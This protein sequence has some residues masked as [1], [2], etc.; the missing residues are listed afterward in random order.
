MLGTGTDPNTMRPPHLRFELEEAE[1]R[2]ASEEAGHYVGKDM[3]MVY[4]TPHGS[5]D[6]IPREP[7]PW[8]E[9]C[10]VDVR[11]G[12]LNP[13]W[14]EYYRLAYKNWKEGLEPPVV[15]TDIKLAGFL[16]PR[17][18]KMLIRLDVRSVEDLAGASDKVL[19]AIGS[20]GRLLQGKAKTWLSAES[21][22]GRVVAQVGELTLRLESLEESLKEKDATIL[23]LTQQVKALEAE[24]PA[25]FKR[26]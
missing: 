13:S 21:G 26:A 15:G 18:L 20:E 22:T 10:A 5:K 8:L 4:I 6:E 3:E 16:T 19:F 12:R 23:R 14:L 9:R 25:E 2:A 17:Q 11:D 7:K 1:D 24:K